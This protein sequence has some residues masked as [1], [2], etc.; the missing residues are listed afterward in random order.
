MNSP[1]HAWHPL[2][3]H[4]PLIAFF[5]AVAFDALDAWSPVPRFRA[6]ATMLWWAALGGAGVAIATGLWAYNLVDH[7]DPAHVIMTRHRNVA[8]GTVALLLVAAFWRWRQV[9]S[10]AAAGLA[11]AGLAGLVWV[12]DMGANLVFGHALGLPTSR[13][14]AI[15][16]ERDGGVG[17]ALPAPPSATAEPAATDS[18]AVPRDTADSTP[19]RKGHTHAPGQGHG[20]GR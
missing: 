3:V 10:R 1:M 6:A 16:R 8:L 7:S 18:P 17:G 2:V 14:E 13:L 15:L 9:R 20:E 4:L 11:L 12:G 5:A 19:V